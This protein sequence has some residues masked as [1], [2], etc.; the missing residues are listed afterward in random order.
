M[1][2]WLVPPIVVPIGIIE[3]VRLIK[4]RGVTVRSVVAEKQAGR[5][6]E[7]GGFEGSSSGVS[8]T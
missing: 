4:E 6:R 2:T 1:K 5:A 3:A 8:L 7:G